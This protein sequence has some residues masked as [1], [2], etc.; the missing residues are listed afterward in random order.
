MACFCA[1]NL[2][3][4]SFGIFLWTGKAAGFC[5]S[6]FETQQGQYRLQFLFFFSFCGKMLKS[7]QEQCYNKEW[8]FTFTCINT[9]LSSVSGT[10]SAVLQ[11]MTETSE[12]GCINE[13][14]LD[15]RIGGKETMCRFKHLLG[16]SLQ[17]FFDFF[18]VSETWNM[19]LLKTRSFRGTTSTS[20][21]PETNKMIG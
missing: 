10:T 13:K 18:K 1:T 11:E 15:R 17:R 8:P 2:F 6:V 9:K 12:T 7:T 19:F 5:T 16:V 4:V 21:R 3:L 20:S 14:L